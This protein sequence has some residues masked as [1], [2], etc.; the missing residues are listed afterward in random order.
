MKYL[1]EENETKTG[2]NLT[3]SPQLE[4]EV[5]AKKLIE[6]IIF[7]SDY[8]QLEA[9]INMLHFGMPPYYKFKMKEGIELT[10]ALDDYFGLSIDSNSKEFLERLC[11]LL[12]SN[13][14]FN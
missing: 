9:E 5:E 10:V 8:F 7:I 6:V 1:I 11:P 3:L 12:E 2:Y 13:I 4:K 14:F